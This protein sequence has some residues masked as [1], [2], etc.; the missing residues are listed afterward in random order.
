MAENYFVG[1]YNLDVSDKIKEKNGLKYLSWA[2]AWASLKKIHPTATYKYYEMPVKYAPDNETP[3]VMRYWFDD[4]KT[5]W[6][7]V[8]ITIDGVE[9]TEILPIMDFKNKPIPA[10]AIDSTAAN[11]S[12]K[13]CLAKCCATHGVGLFIYEGED[14]PEESKLN[15][16]LQADCMELIRKKCALSEK[17][18]AKVGAICKEVLAE[19]NGD[20]NLCEDNAKLKELKK[21]LMAVRKIV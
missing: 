2:A 17:T 6:V 8:G 4:G 5:G 15:N 20:P 16:S 14:M 18:K 11:K 7:K 21:K 10:D 12:L 3:I 1:L 19:E 13:R 9:H